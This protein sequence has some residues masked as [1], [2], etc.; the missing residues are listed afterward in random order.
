MIIK[1]LDKEYELRFGLKALKY[2]DDIYFI[3]NNG[4]KF[5][6]GVF[7]VYDALSNKSDFNAIAIFNLIKAGLETSLIKPN[8]RQIEMYIEQCVTDDKADELVEE[9]LDEL[10]KQPLTR[11]KI[12][13]ATGQKFTKKAK[14]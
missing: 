2:L 10:K 13:K 12:E 6:L 8:D 14:K 3:E 1:I 7:Q 5:G 11:L 9:L 4:I